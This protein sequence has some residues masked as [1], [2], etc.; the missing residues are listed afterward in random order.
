MNPPTE[1]LIRDYLNRL[2]VAARSELAP[3]DRQALL[4][5]T[6]ARIE[7]GCDPRSATAAQVRKVLADL[8]DPV[9]LVEAERCRAGARDGAL[10]MTAAGPPGRPAA[11][12]LDAPVPVNGTAG[13][14][15]DAAGDAP[16]LPAP[17][18]PAE[19]G[20]GDL[21]A[22]AAA[23]ADGGGQVGA[24]EDF[25]S[26]PSESG[27]GAAAAV[28]AETEAGAGAGAGAGAEV[29]AD[30]AAGAEAAG[31]EAGRKPAPGARRAAARA[32]SSLRPG[33]RRAARPATASGSRAGSP[34]TSLVRGHKLEIV[35]LLLL[36]VGGAFFPP[37]WILG[38]LLAMAVPPRVWDIRDKWTG[39]AAPVL[40]TIAGTVLVV[41]LGGRRGSIGSYA[42]EAWVA[43]GRLSRLMAVAGAAYLAWRLYRG[44]R[45]PRQPPWK[46]PKRLDL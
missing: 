23:P 1:Q 3:A 8:G 11:G 20:D 34:A 10:A 5:Q 27:A 2:A 24:P 28:E 33:F 37:V 9:A 18:P 13:G 31:A 6:R 30:A 41:L 39:L 36:G 15:N 44:R 12:F 38:A 21:A 40:L 14:A 19:A 26:L 16:R 35:A 17:R 42:F 43:A 46:V 45:E 25:E 29:E 7:A 32:A 4:S 22:P